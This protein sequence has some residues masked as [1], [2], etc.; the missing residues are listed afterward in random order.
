MYYQCYNELA[1]HTLQVN[2]RPEIHGPASIRSRSD[3]TRICL[4]WSLPVVCLLCSN[5]RSNWPATIECKI[6]LVQLNYHSY[7]LNLTQS[8]W[9]QPLGRFLVVSNHKQRPGFRT[10]RQIEEDIAELETSFPLVKFE[11]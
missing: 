5:F 11:E 4:T 6:S 2:Q 1:Q 10:R 3:L 7:K 9:R 8:H